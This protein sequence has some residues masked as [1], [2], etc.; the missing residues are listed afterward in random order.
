LGDIKLELFC[1]EAPLAGEVSS[2]LYQ[3]LFISHFYRTLWL[4]VL[5]TIMTIASFTETLKDLL[6][7]LATQQEQVKVARVFGK[8]LLR[9]NSMRI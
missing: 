6:C 1:T 8:N 9:M 3:N 2:D 7:K 4:S 5:P